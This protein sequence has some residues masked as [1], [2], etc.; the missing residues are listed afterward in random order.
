MAINLILKILLLLILTQIVAQDI[1]ERKVT[2]FLFI[3]SILILG[4]LHFLNVEPINFLTSILMN[5][6]IVILLLSILSLY[7]K[8]K[9]KKPLK[10][11]FGMGDAVFFL[12]FAFAFPTY[13]FLV[14]F[15]FSLFFTGVIFFFFKR[16]LY[17][18][19]VPLAGLQA[20]F[21]TLVFISNWFFDFVDLYFI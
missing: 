7:S 6:T 13:S 15:S 12:A 3:S 9:L 10:E 18:K 11:T 1:K 20:L 8:F 2:L 16:K 4:Y 14:L 19:T 17:H 21:L 5:L